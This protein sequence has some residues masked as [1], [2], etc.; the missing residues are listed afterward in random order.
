MQKLDDFTHDIKKIFGERLK[1]IFI[2]GSK[3]N[4]NAQQTAGDTDIMVIAENITGDDLRKCTKPVKK[5]MGSCCIFD[6]EKNPLPIFMGEREWFNSVD[7]YA[8]EYSDIKENYNIIYGEN[9]INNLTVK[10][11]DLRL[12][13]ESEMKNL[14]MRFRKQYILFADDYNAV[15]KSLLVVTKTLNAIFKAILRIKDIEV[16]K[17]AFDNLNKI[18]EIIDIDKTFYEKLLCVK[19]N[20]CKFSKTE[21]YK[22]ADEAIVQM[23]KLLEYIN[24]M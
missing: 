18:V 8:M 10:K 21:T 20:H 19:E 14:L 5:W 11:E 16:S 15:N 9:L 13:C 3:A 4:A 12:Q 24:N 7:V 22:I 2:Y 17:S 23:D 6:K 1:S